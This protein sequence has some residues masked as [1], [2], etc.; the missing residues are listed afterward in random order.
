MDTADRASRTI[1]VVE[2]DRDCRDVLCRLLRSLR[3]Q[4]VG[5][6]TVGEALAALNERP[7]D[8][9]ILDLMLPDRSGVEVLRFI[10]QNQLGTKVAILSG[11]H[12]P[13]GFPGL[14]ELRPDVILRKPVD[15][16]ALNHWLD[17]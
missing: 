9:A 1:L 5:C 11:H 2:D 15:V 8:R 3:H 4:A 17:H 16:S 6:E 12:D 14:A 7:V 13:E 10:R